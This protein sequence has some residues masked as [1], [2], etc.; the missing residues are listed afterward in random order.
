MGSLPRFCSL[1]L[2]GSG[3]SFRFWIPVVRVRDLMTRVSL[4]ACSEEF[5]TLHVKDNDPKVARHSEKH[6]SGLARFSLH[7]VGLR[8]AGLRAIVLQSP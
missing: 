2:F 3:F 8:G 7:R 1:D 4:T 6:H 5:A